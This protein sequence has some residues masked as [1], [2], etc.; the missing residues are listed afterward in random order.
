MTEPPPLGIERPFTD[1]GLTASSQSPPRQAAK[2]AGREMC[3]VHVHALGRAPRLQGE[4]AR[5]ERRRRG[6]HQ[7]VRLALQPGALVSTLKPLPCP[8]P[9]LLWRRVTPP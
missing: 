1:K 8:S 6:R 4:L 9:R 5:G 3:S 2:G 7:V